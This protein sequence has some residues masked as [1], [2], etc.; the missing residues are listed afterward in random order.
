MATQ[1]IQTVTKETQKIVLKAIC[2]FPTLTIEELSLLL[3]SRMSK[4]SQDEIIQVI[5]GIAPNKNW[6]RA[7][8]DDVQ[9]E[10]LNYIWTLENQI[11]FLLPTKQ[12]E[13]TI[14]EFNQLRL[15]NKQPKVPKDI[16]RHL[17]AVLIVDGK[18]LARFRKF[19]KDLSIQNELDIN[20]QAG[21]L[22]RILLAN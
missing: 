15:Q 3:K 18:N 20:V 5:H 2:E 16:I 22:I 6:H 1:E 11:L 14:A 19:Q 7:N 10:L 9:K 21:W 17:Q 12:K 13:T 8:Q 4:I